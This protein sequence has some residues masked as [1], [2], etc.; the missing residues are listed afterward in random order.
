MKKEW[1]YYS[2]DDAVE[3]LDT[4][5]KPINSK[6]RTKRIEGISESELYPY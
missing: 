5:R 3:I 4:L 1:V 2:L 6:E